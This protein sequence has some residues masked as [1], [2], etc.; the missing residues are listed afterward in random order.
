M[1][2][3]IVF[4][5]IWQFYL[6]RQSKTGYIHVVVSVT[7]VAGNSSDLGLLCFCLHFT[8]EFM[9]QLETKAEFI[10]IT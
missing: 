5:R 1:D 2:S 6:R 4:V 3:V 10:H 8:Q 7:Y 9:V